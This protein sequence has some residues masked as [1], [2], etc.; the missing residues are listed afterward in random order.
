MDQNETAIQQAPEALPSQRV[1]T[2]SGILAGRLMVTPQ[3]LLDTIK[4]QVFGGIEA[5]KVTTSHL[6]VVADLANQYGLHPFHDFQAFIANGRVNVILKPEG[7][8]RLMQRDPNIEDEGYEIINDDKGNLLAVEAWAK[9]KN[10]LSPTRYRAFLSEWRIGSNPNWAA[11]PAHM[12]M[13]RAKK[14]LFRMIFPG[15]PVDEPEEIIATTYEDRPAPATK[16][17]RILSKIQP[18]VSLPPAEP[19]M[20]TLDPTP[21][22]ADEPQGQNPGVSEPQE[23]N[24]PVEEPKAEE[25]PR[26]RR[27]V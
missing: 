26:R 1:A 19:V 13:I 4:V 22:Y 3:Q 11:R 16:A 2:L 14:H 7:V 27:D 21:D 20:T 8:F 17:E 5:S 18:P 6:M 10:R 15:I 12:L 25:K 9:L 24:P 23:A